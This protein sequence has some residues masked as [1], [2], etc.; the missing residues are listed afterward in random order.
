VCAVC[1]HVHT[2]T[3]QFTFFSLSVMVV[4][5]VNCFLMAYG[6]EHPDAE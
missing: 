4:I 2:L 5:L 1:A 3:A 6:F